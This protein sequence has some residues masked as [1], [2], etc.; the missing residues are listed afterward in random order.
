MRLHREIDDRD[1]GRIKDL[2]R[3]L[4]I[5]RFLYKSVIVLLILWILRIVVS[6]YPN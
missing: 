3:A 2:H 1:K 6:I 5:R 4:P